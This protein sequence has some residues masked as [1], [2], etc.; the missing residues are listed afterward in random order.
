MSDC[1]EKK[2]PG[3]GQKL[4]F[5]TNVGGLVMVCPSCGKKFHS[6]FKLSGTEG[7]GKEGIVATIF[8]M[9]CTVLN[10]LGRFFS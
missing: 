5:P 9:P 8:E 4:R 7:R 1:I 6:D 10:R 3:C 2:C